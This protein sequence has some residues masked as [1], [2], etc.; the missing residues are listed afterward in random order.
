MA[1]GQVLNTV[2][3]AK[4]TAQETSMINCLMSNGDES[5]LCRKMPSMSHGHSNII[6]LMIPYSGSFVFNAKLIAEG[7]KV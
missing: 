7:S 2:W 4:Q 6:L 1:S 3:W 5:A